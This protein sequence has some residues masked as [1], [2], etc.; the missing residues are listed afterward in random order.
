MTT[1]CEVT[2]DIR[3]NGRVMKSKSAHGRRW[4]CPAQQD[5]VVLLEACSH[6]CSM[7]DHLLGLFAITLAGLCGVMIIL[8]PIAI[9]MWGPL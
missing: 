1:F 9:D 7:T 2:A 8:L 6:G 3:I 4:A 5:R